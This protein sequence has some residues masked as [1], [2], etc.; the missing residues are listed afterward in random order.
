MSLNIGLTGGIGSGKSEVAQIFQECGDFII[1]YD[2]LSREV[3]FENPTLVEKIAA[4]FQNPKKSKFQQWIKGDD[5]EPENIDIKPLTRKEIAEIVF[6]DRKKLK[7]LE[8]LTHPIIIDLAFATKKKNEDKYQIFINE[9]PMLFEAKLQKYF[10]YI[11]LVTADPELKFQ[12]LY[13]NRGMDRMEAKSRMNNQL[14][15]RKKI[16]NVD[17]VIENNGSLEELKNKV[18]E[19][20]TF[21]EEKLN[22]QN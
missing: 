10:D 2:Q 6:Q 12:R 17:F 11:I 22:S 19:L 1:D 3:E 13:E 5:D 16:K 4:I 9:I 20:Q 15:D 8:A 7:K 18:L 21:F 14:D